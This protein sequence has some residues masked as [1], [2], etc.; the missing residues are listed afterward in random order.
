MQGIIN[1]V[2][3]W[4]NTQGAICISLEDIKKFM[5]FESLDDAIN[6]LYFNDYKTE[7]RHLNNV[8][9]ES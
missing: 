9:K 7:A 8:K 1:K 5:T 6:W 2:H 3:Y 4:Q